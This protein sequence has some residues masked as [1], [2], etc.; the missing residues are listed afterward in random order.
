MPTLIILIVLV[1]KLESLLYDG[2]LIAV[3]SIKRQELSTFDVA[4]YID[5][6]MCV[7]TKYR[8][9]LKKRKLVIIYFFLSALL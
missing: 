5:N 7:N 3:S 6:S 2:I 9:E 8:V 4:F 1:L